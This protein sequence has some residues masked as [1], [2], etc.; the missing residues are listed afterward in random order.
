MI[1]YISNFGS[2]IIVE[3]SEIIKKIIYIFK[4]ILGND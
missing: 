2:N 3:N 1:I 4:L